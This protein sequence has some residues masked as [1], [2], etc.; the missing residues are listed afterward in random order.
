MDISKEI[1]N[2]FKSTSSNANNKTLLNLLLKENLTILR[3]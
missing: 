1:K 3:L 2:S